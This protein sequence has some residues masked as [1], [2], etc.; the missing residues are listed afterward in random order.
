ML[1]ELSTVKRRELEKKIIEA[2]KD[3]VK[4]LPEELQQ[5]LADDLVTAFQNRKAVLLKILSK[6]EGHEFKYMMS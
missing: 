2:L 6:Y 1:E 5:M 4:M 3:E